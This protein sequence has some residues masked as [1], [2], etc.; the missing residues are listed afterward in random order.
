MGKN[1]P[2]KVITEISGKACWAGFHYGMRSI[3]V[4]NDSEQKMYWMK[5]GTEIADGTMVSAGDCLGME[6]D[7]PMLIM[8]GAPRYKYPKI[9]PIKSNVLCVIEGDCFGADGRY[10]IL[11]IRIM[12]RENGAE[13]GDQYYLEQETLEE[14][15]YRAD[16]SI[17]SGRKISNIASLYGFHENEIS[18][19]EDDTPLQIWLENMCQQRRITFTCPYDILSFL[20]NRFDNFKQVFERKSLGIIVPDKKEI[21]TEKKEKNVWEQ[22]REAAMMVIEYDRASEYCTRFIIENAIPCSENFEPDSTDTTLINVL[23]QRYEA[24]EDYDTCEKLFRL[25]NGFKFPEGICSTDLADFVHSSKAVLHYDRN[26]LTCWKEIELLGMLAL[27]P[28]IKKKDDD[29]DSLILV[30]KMLDYFQVKREIEK[31]EV[32]TRMKQRISFKRQQEYN[33]QKKNNP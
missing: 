32:L 8:V 20:H 19:G 24:T 16:D 18:S 25:Q 29:I 17:L 10:Y 9:I 33:R 21:K 4:E 11:R 7:I 31:C 2:T 5:P 14:N 12:L 13:Y 23:L 22:Y 28:V 15:F 30:E 1:I 27:S 3:I 26:V 6:G